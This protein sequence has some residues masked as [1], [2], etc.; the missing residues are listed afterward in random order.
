MMLFYNYVFKLKEYVKTVLYILG[1]HK[2][3]LP[4]VFLLFFLSSALDLIGISLIFPLIAVLQGAPPTEIPIAFIA[5]AIFK[6]ADG[7]HIVLTSCTL[8]FLNFCVKLLLALWINYYTLSYCADIQATLRS[9]LFSA[10]INMKWETFAVKNPS[11]FLDS[12]HRRVGQYVHST[13]YNA[14]KTVSEMIILLALIIFISIS[15]PLEM[16][17]I[18]TVGVTTLGTLFFAFRNTIT[19]HGSL[20]NKYSTELIQNFNEGIR[21]K[22]EVVILKKQD[23]FRELVY[24]SA[25]HFGNSQK[26][27][28]FI[29]G[30][31]RYIIE[32]AAVAF[33]LIAI[34]LIYVTSEQNSDTLNFFS[35]LAIASIKFLPS[36]YAISQSIFAMQYAKPSVEGLAKE[37]KELG[38]TNSQNIQGPLQFS[39]D[40]KEL[41][42]DSVEFG[43]PGSH[44]CLF[45]DL[46]ICI[47]Q[48]TITSFIGRSGSGKSSLLDLIVG[49][50]KPLKG[51]IEINSLPL[52]EIEKQW[53]SKIA[54]VPQRPFVVSRSIAQNISLDFKNMPN[55][56]EREKLEY[57]SSIAYLSKAF[58]KKEVNLDQILKSDSLNISGGQ[59]QRLSIARALYFDREIIILDEPTSSLDKEVEKEVLVGLKELVPEKTLILSTH[60]SA[61][62]EIS[63]QVYSIEDGKVSKLKG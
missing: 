26:I 55:Q 10:Y 51:N 19:K 41:K 6:N 58:Q 63:D 18:L 36:S 16:L 37:L 40:F 54:F 35:T 11:A 28:L 22:K 50:S 15:F 44:S 47:K 9:K 46:N 24:D 59:L 61:A 7:N 32:F 42:I 20:T 43:Y 34:A 33:V 62:I 21:A 45:K 29:T 1:T 52:E 48:G 57:Y 5:N 2:K 31:A 13:L 53:H 3:R 38:R 14:L 56:V 60:S 8:L 23:E 17:I 39:E 27:S 4:F 49:F 12:M 25:T 30:S